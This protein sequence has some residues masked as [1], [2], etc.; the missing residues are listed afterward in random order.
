MKK[1]ITAVLLVVAVALS[2]GATGAFAA[3]SS[4][5]DGDTCGPTLPAGRVYLGD[6]SASVVDANP[7]IVTDPSGLDL[8]LHQYESDTE[9]RV[10]NEQE[11]VSVT[12][13]GIDGGTYTGYVDSH[14]IHQEP[15][16]DDASDPMRGRGCISFAT[17]I[18]GVIT[19]D[20][21]L[22]ASDSVVGLTTVTYPTGLALRGLEQGSGRGY[23]D[24]IEVD[25][26][27]IKVDLQSA[28]IMDQIRV[29]TEPESEPLVTNLCAGQDIDIGN[30]IVENDGTNLYVTYEITEP[31]WL[32]VETHLEVVTDPDDFPTAKSKKHNNPIPGHFTWSNDHSP[33]VETFTYTIPL[34][35]IG[36]GVATG[37]PVYIAA[38][39]EVYL[40]EAVVY[41]TE[42]GPGG[43]IDNYGDIYEIDLDSGTATYLF[44]PN[45]NLGQ[46]NYPNGNA[47]DTVNNRLY[48]SSNDSESTPSDLYFYD[49]ASSQ[50]FTGTLDGVSAGASFYNGK[51]YYIANGTDDLMEVALYAGGTIASE[52][53]IAD[54]TGNA[55]GWGFGDIVIR[56]D[57]VLFGSP[58]GEFFKFDLNTL[59]YTSISTT[60]AV[61]MQLAFG[62]NGVLYGHSA[63]T[64]EFFTIDPTDGTTTSIGYVTGSATGQFTDLA[65]GPL[66]S[67][68]ETAWGGACDEEN[69]WDGETGFVYFFNPDGKGN[70]AS[71]FKYTIQ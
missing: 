1:K 41:G 54:I 12:S 58:G 35:D 39:A 59:T 25:G 66:P 26:N 48:Y 19:S 3:V 57:G 60:G 47:F 23:Q 62:S 31:G 7:V 24:V 51:Y 20:A 21:L 43:T 46:R 18:V 8:T 36:G 6:N 50:T 9:I 55:K 15:T 61:G 64:G 38:H 69:Y 14:I 33:P 49:F 68:W 40:T 52:T 5:E 28:E 17:A 37:D 32:L 4:T 53:K 10:F 45:L 63:G 27:T 29:L 13:L 44:R 65:S 16:P 42:R 70:W 34:A 67:V 30:T 2:L 11:N 56:S 71:Y 22:D